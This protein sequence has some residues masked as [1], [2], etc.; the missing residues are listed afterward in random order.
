[1][2]KGSRVSALKSINLTIG[3]LLELA[4][5][6]TVAFWGLTSS[7]PIPGRVILGLMLPTVVVVFWALFMA[8][9]AKRRIPDRWEPVVALVM[10]LGAAVLL[11]M[12]GHRTA[13]GVFALVAV[14]NTIGV[15]ALRRYRSPLDGGS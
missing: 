5:I 14:L 3:F 12:S 7:M 4:L 1:L 13:G 2:S 15:Y 10:F 6:G 9:R 8:P 11:I